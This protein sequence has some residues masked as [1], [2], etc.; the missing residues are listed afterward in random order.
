[1]KR[2]WMILVLMFTT[3][4]S[5][6]GLVVREEPV[7]TKPEV[8]LDKKVAEDEKA[9]AEEK[10]KPAKVRKKETPNERMATTE[11]ELMEEITGLIIEETMTRIGYEFYEF[12]FTHW[13][14]PKGVKDYNISI[15]ERAS[16]LWGS[17]IQVKIDANVV[18]SKLLKPRSEE[19]EEAAKQAVKVTKEFLSH[20]EEYKRELEGP[21]M[22]GSGI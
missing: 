7:S 18:W 2:F 20:Y 21:D 11:Q 6:H 10:E 22:V 16:P 1:M 8:K 9:S 3:S 19:I 14:A 13:E 12:F 15:D 17:W 5:I 4:C